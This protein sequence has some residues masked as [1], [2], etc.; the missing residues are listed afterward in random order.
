VL[1]RVRRFEAKDAAVV[2]AIYR[3]CIE[4]AK[5]LPPEAKGKKDFAADTRGEAMFVSVGANDE[6]DGF[7]SVWERR[8]F[9]HH[10][11]VL[12]GARRAGVGSALLAALD[13]LYPKPWRLKCVVANEVA[14]SFYSQQ[15]WSEVSRGTGDDG[16]FILLER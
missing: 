11:Y 10:L 13:D 15:G 4:E 8:S 12:P 2:A 6:P 16:A 5:W 14:R 3:E 9:I 7:V 1:R